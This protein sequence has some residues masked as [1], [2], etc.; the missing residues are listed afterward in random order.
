MKNKKRS[1][2]RGPL[3]WLISLLAFV[4]L[5]SGWLIWRD[6]LLEPPR[7]N[8]I[9]ISMNHESLKILSGET[10]RFHPRDRVKILKISTNIPLG[11]G[12]RLT[13]TGFDVNALRYEEMSLV[14]LLPDREM[15]EHYRYRIQI[16]HLN[17]N[18]GHVD[19]EIRPYA[20]DWIDKAERIINSDRRLTMLER[21]R[22]FLPED[23]LV[24]RRLLDEYKSLERW[25][26][27]ARMIEEVAGKGAEM[28]ILHELL[29]V[30]TA[31]ANNDGVISILKRFVELDTDDLEAL[32]RLAE[33]Y[34]KQ[35]NL[36]AAIQAHEALLGRMDT[37]DKLPVFKRLGY[38]CA[39][40]GKTRKALSYYLKAADLDKTDA[41]L[42]YNLSYVYK[43]L[44][45]GAKADFYL[46]KA[47]RLKTQDLDGR[48][49]LAQSL[50]NRGELKKTEKY[51]STILAKKPESLKALLLM[52]Q[53]MEKKGERQKLRDIYKRILLLDQKN[54]T[55]LYN[56]GSLE[57]EAGELEESLYHLK[58]YLG[59]QPKDAAVHTMVFTIY[60]SQKKRKEA[61]NEARILAELRPR[62]V[63]SYHYMFD[64]LKPQGYYEKIISIMS[65]GVKANPG[66]VALREYLVLAYLETGRERLAINQIEEIL[67]VRSKDIDLLLHLARLREK[68]GELGMALKA[69]KKVVD[70]SPGHEEAE[71]AYL[72]LKLEGVRG[73]RPR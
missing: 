59:L 72:R 37:G 11:L 52:A 71:E 70:L 7:I 27:S 33:A 64:Y 21:A 61:L 28:Q 41:N 10:V 54:E 4:G 56:L 24:W 66:E 51:L 46:D 3:F 69:Y 60:K 26:E 36:K 18:L 14:A 25:E 62:E 44:H 39:E 8:F 68:Q 35:G 57:Y 47:V 2:F 12:V 9:L 43:K 34:E 58:T 49:E 50:L 23:G 17:R 63:S 48:L 29:E 67:K 15:F 22:D 45:N 73:G 16:K 40:A 53:L 5:A 30:Y 19:W 31:M 1:S 42:Y 38:V 65:M 32:G 20:E 6:R 55:V 13:A